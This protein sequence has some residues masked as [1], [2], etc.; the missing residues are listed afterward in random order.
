MGKD[1]PTASGF[2]HSITSNHTYTMIHQ[3]PFLIVRL[4]HRVKERLNEDKSPM[5]LCP[6]EMAVSHFKCNPVVLYNLKEEHDVGKG[7]CMDV[8]E[9]YLKD[10]YCLD[11]TE[12]QSSG[13]EAS[14][15][16]GASAVVT[17][18]NDHYS[19]GETENKSSSGIS[20]NRNSHNNNKGYEVHFHG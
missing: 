8:L 17:D 15:D 6:Q 14:E 3:L 10:N 2:L 19:I 1:C 4:I 12:A 13:G 5:K 20:V 18:L 11:E 9:N 7:I 16:V